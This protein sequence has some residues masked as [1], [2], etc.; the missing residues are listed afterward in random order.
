ML[1]CNAFAVVVVGRWVGGGGRFHW[2]GGAESASG[3]PSM[4]LGCFFALGEML[5][6]GL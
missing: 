2:F 3:L 5:C 4:S 6:D 1:L